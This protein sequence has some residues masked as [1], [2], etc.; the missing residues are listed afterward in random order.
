MPKPMLF[1]HSFPIKLSLGT[2]AICRQPTERTQ[3]DAVEPLHFTS[4]TSFLD[5]IAMTSH[6]PPVP[7]ANRSNKAPGSDPESNQ[8]TSVKHPIPKNAAEQGETANIKQ[9]TTNKGY[10]HGR[11][12]K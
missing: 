1:L 7:P 2:E 3:H 10:F 9:N 12:M 11:R 6:M 4:Q 8:D 5:D